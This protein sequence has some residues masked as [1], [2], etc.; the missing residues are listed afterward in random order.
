MKKK[1]KPTNQER[2]LLD[3]AQGPHDHSMELCVIGCIMLDSSCFYQCQESGLTWAHF[4]NEDH[5]KIYR[6]IQSMAESR[7]SA[8]GIDVMTVGSELHRTI[9]RQEERIK[10]MQAL[11]ASSGATPTAANAIFY[12]REVVEFATRRL[13]VAEGQA[14]AHQAE[15]VGIDS[16]EIT[17]F[18]TRIAQL[19]N[20][21]RLSRGSSFS[22]ALV[23]EMRTI[24]DEAEGKVD[25]SRQYVS[26]GLKAYD[27]V[28][29]GG[30]M[31]GWPHMVG[32]R[33]AMG[34]SSLITHAL[35]NLRLSGGHG[36]LVSLEMP[37]EQIIR[38][39]LEA[40]SRV[41][42][43]RP[44][45][46]SE[47]EEQRLTNAFSKLVNAKGDYWIRDSPRFDIMQLRA[48][49]VE[50]IETW[51][52]LDMV[53]IDYLQR[54]RIPGIKE[55]KDAWDLV[56]DQTAEIAKEFHIALVWLVQLNRDL[57]KRP[58]KAPIMS[59]FKGT[60]AIEE[61]TYSLTGLWRPE[62]YD[63]D[64]EHK[65]K[66]FLDVLKSKDSSPGTATVGWEGEFTRFYDL[67]D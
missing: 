50:A 34:K 64:T 24:A 9:K 55:Q 26:T 23:S 25:R 33:P 67:E 49:I 40:S 56:I 47:M 52:S 13:V 16:E 51:G 1:T 39:Q 8:K 6:A 65:G 54:V 3:A 32:A 28:L 12:A 22:D 46:L 44:E 30:W 66:A 63:P 48:Q 11:S 17:A 53:A 60:G 18:G 21:D 42:L 29:D 37:R 14:I 31:R 15:T 38:R 19:T 59:D 61:A 2:R 7:G 20:K 5:R 10:L 41:K 27:A 45:L 43:R 58:D 4:H 36:I 35:N 57:E 62:R